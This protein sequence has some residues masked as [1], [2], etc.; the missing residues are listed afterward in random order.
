MAANTAYLA[1]GEGET[2]FSVSA[3]PIKF[4]AGALA[5]LGADAAV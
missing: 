5:E 4:G 2:I 3:S 1:P